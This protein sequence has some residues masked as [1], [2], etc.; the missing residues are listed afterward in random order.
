MEKVIKVLE[1]YKNHAFGDKDN[2]C[3][4]SDIIDLLK[5][6]EPRVLDFGEI[7][8]M[9]N[10]DVFFEE[11]SSCLVYPLMLLSSENSNKSQKVFFFPMAVKPLR[12]YG[13]TWRCW[14]SRPSD[15][16]R[17]AEPWN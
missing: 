11:R 1:G 8:T 3:T 13:T 14:T 10:V 6:Q 9:A 5:A 16:Q 15:A 4:V 7:P 2:K 12:T 17:E